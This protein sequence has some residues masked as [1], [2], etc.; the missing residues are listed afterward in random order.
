MTRLPV[1]FGKVCFAVKG[2]PTSG[3]VASIVPTCANLQESGSTISVLAV[4]ATP[5]ASPQSFAAFVVASSGKWTER[6]PF[7][8]TFSI[9]VEPATP[10]WI[11]WSIILMFVL[12]LLM[13][14]TAE[15]RETKRPRRK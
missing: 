7:S 4:E 12:I 15:T 3:F 14:S 6:V 13:P 1:S 8:I 10:A 5:A 2:F 11:P 9:T